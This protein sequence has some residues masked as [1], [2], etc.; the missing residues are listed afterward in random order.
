MLA[1]YNSNIFDTVIHSTLLTRLSTRSGI[2][3]K[4]LTWFK[5]YLSSRSQFVSNN[6]S[7]SKSNVLLTGVPKGSLFNWLLF[8]IPRKQPTFK[9]CSIGDMILNFNYMLMT[10]DLTWF[11]IQHVP[12]TL[13]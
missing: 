9:Y 10:H 1:V 11:S 7:T 8:S 4:A 3:G 13:I 12:G 2:A 6:A 5:S